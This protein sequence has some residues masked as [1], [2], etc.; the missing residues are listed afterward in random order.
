MIKLVLE[1]RC[2][3]LQHTVELLSYELMIIRLNEKLTGTAC[4]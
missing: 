2:C 1:Y 3:M 4:S